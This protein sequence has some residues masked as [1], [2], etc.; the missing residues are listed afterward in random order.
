MADQVTSVHGVRELRERAGHLLAGAREEFLCAADDPS[1]FALPGEP[2]RR[3][4]GLAVRKLHT[5][6]VL[7]RPEALAYLRTITADGGRVRISAAPLGHEAIVLDRRVAILAGRVERGE[8]RYGVVTDPDVVA[9]I[10]SLFDAAWESGT[11]LA[12]VPDPADGPPPA[13]DEELRP[14]LA[15]LGEGCTDE[16][17]ARR[18]GVSVRTYRRRVADLMAALGATSRFQAGLRAPRL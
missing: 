16:V 6:R 5:A 10:G 12:D 4:P 18:L 3:S 8:R 13:L 9:G 15:L 1:T 11:D 7:G 2:P 14:V 17:A